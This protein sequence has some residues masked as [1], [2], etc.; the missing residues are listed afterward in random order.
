M[1]DKDKDED[2]KLQWWERWVNYNS[3]NTLPQWYPPEIAQE[4]WVDFFAE[5]VAANL[6]PNPSVNMFVPWIKRK[7]LPCPGPAKPIELKDT[8]R[9]VPDKA[10]KT[11]RT[12]FFYLRLVNSCEK[13]RCEHEAVGACAIEI[14][15][16][17]G[18]KPIKRSFSPI[19]CSVGS[20]GVLPPGAPGAPVEGDL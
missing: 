19:S 17:E 6:P 15:E 18:C 7:T 1:W 3:T 4:K 13:E 12:I 5:A 14:F 9:I 20:M 16:Y 2:C 11:T 10:K 8:T